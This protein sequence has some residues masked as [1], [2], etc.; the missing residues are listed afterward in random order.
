MDFNVVSPKTEEDLLSVISENQGSEFRFGAGFT[1]LLLELKG[2]FTSG[3]KVIN[4]SQLNEEKFNN[5]ID[6]GDYIHVGTNVTSQDLIES[7]LLNMNYN[8][9]KEAANS[10]AS[11][12][13]RNAATIGGNICTAS[14]SGDMSCAL[15]S[16]Q[17]ICEILNTNGEIREE[18]LSEFIQN[19][20][21]TSLAKNEILR[22]VKIPKNN[23]EKQYSG[24]IKV[25]NR[26]SM[27]IS[28]VSFAY[29]LQLNTIDK[30][31]KAGIAIGSVAP[32]IP[33]AKD[34]CIYLEGKIF[35]QIL[36]NEREELAKKVL[37][38][39][40]PIS[41]IRASEWYRKEVLYNICR[42]I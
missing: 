5:I 13:I 17:S 35:N 10:V 22:N 19:V 25:G 4:I 40:S 24:F 38:Y 20:R 8:V 11:T 2:R 21:K 41:D 15:I 37:Q 33:F 6:M 31:I 39:A 12:Q 7:A 16:L 28:I 1:D 9:L 34:A 23:T 32:R 26:N 36:L 42:D 29:H 30:I 18:S 3:L 14:P 27:E